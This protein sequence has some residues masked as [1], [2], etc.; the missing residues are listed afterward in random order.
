MPFVVLIRDDDGEWSSANSTNTIYDLEAG[1]ATITAEV[2]HFSTY[3]AWPLIG[4]V[5]ID[6]QP[7]FYA[8]NP[9]DQWPAT[10]DF[11]NRTQGSMFIIGLNETSVMTVIETGVV[12]HLGPLSLGG[13][14]MREPARRRRAGG[15]RAG[16]AG[17][18]HG[19][20]GH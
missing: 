11:W 15:D 17:R 8:G 13:E 5:R 20:A 4:L 12:S 2:S 9:G 6:F 1:T 19:H 18:H 10:F 7:P 3:M 16:G 14:E